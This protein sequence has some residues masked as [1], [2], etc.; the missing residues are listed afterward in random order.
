MAAVWITGG[1]QGIGRALALHYAAAGAAVAASARTAEDLA[2]VADEAAALGGKVVPFPL[3]VTD[4][5]ATAAAVDAVER[6]IGPLDLCILN[7]G[8]HAPMTAADFS[9]DTLRRLVDVNVLG[10]AHGLEAVLPRFLARRGGHVAVVGSA[11]AYV[12]L[13]TAAAYGATKAALNNLCEA[14]APELRRAGVTI[15]IV[16]P[17]FVR[18]PL[19]DRNTF[20]MPFLMDAEDAAA[21]I[22]RGLARGRFEVAFP[23]RLVLPLKLLRCLP[24]AALFVLSRRMLP[25]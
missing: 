7:A 25:R 15:S 12:G 4:R 10:V 1:G 17:G 20:R 23:R 21:R 3:D 13:P 6:A 9:S 14:L 24:R 8:T 22:A 2:L 11:S 18:T 16:N 5:D 19:T